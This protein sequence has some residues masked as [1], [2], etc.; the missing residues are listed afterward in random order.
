MCLSLLKSSIGKKQIVATT[1]LLLIFFLIG[2]LIGNF[3]IYGGPDL[4]NGYAAMLKKAKPVVLF[5]E[6]AL[7]AVFLTHVLVTIALVH[8]N[9]KAAGANRYAVPNSRGKRSLATQLR[10]YTGVFLL[11]F[12][13]WHLFDFT[14]ADHEGVRSIIQNSP[15]GLY[16][17]VYNSFLNPIHSLLYI[18]AMASLGFHLAHG[19]QSFIQTFGFNHPKY[20]PAVLKVSNFFGIFIALA[21]SSIPI[22]VLIRG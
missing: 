13:V 3:L 18:I 22:Y 14:F 8:D 19:V 11:G 5:I 20:T 7:L 16:G 21:F 10:F 12:V 2:H 1:G 6:L 9:Q 4:F 17:V 15:L